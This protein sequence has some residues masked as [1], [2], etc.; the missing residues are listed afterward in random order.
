MMPTVAKV[1]TASFC[2]DFQK[3]LFCDAYANLATC[4]VQRAISVSSVYDNVK[5][6]YELSYGSKRIARKLF[7]IKVL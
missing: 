2:F 6:L 5:R 7:Q 4:N 3:K 1:S